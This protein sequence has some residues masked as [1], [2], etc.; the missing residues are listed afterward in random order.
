ML[1]RRPAYQY[2]HLQYLLL[3]SCERTIAFTPM[4]DKKYFS[5]KQFSYF[6]L[7]LIVIIGLFGLGHSLVQLIAI[8]LSVDIE[9]IDR[10]VMY[11][12]SKYGVSSGVLRVSVFV[13][14]TIAAAYIFFKDVISRRIPYY[15]NILILLLFSLFLL[16]GLSDFEVL[17]DRLFRLTAFFFVIAV[18]HIFYCLKKKDQVIFFAIVITICNLFPYIEPGNIRLL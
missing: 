8:I 10:L 6:L 3:P 17:A 15:D 13:Y 16:L 4:V 18:G 1:N 11:S 14:V 9:I 2:F 12:D 7:S 5:L